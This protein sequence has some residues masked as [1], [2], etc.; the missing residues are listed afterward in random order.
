MPSA[1]SGEV[2]HA[3]SAALE[4]GVHASN[5]YPVKMPARVVCGA[6]EPPDAPIR[7]AA[8]TTAAM[9]EL[10][11]TPHEDCAHVLGKSDSQVRSANHVRTWFER[12]SRVSSS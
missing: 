2:S 4:G 1:R 10:P 6:A 5:A 8:A 11:L 9:S 7:T 3:F 12:G